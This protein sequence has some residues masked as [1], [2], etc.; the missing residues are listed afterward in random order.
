[1]AV[2][3]ITLMNFG[4]D[5]VKDYDDIFTVIILVMTVKLKTTMLTKMD[6]VITEIDTD[7]HDVKTNGKLTNSL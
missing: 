4:S 5:Y 2:V 3:T 7:F 6:C 1:M